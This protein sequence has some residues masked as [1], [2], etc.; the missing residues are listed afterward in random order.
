M[1]DRS[2]G[3]STSRRRFIGAA[4]SAVVGAGVASGLP[5]GDGGGS[6][7]AGTGAGTDGSADESTGGVQDTDTPTATPTPPDPVW[8]LFQFDIANTGHQPDGR[9]PTDAVG[10]EWA[11]VDGGSY[12]TTPVVTEAE[13]FA[14]DDD[15]VVRALDVDS[16]A[17]RWAVDVPLSNSRMTIQNRVLYVPNGETGAELQALDAATGRRL[18]STSL[19]GGGNGAVATGDSVY[20]ATSGGVAKVSTLSESVSW[21]FGDI[22]LVDST[23][24]VAG[25]SVY[26][27]GTR[28]GKVV[29]LDVSS[30][31]TGWTNFVGGS[32]VDAP[33]VAGS[34]VF[35]PFGEHLVALRTDSGREL[36][37][38]EQPVGSSVVVAGDTVYGTTTRGEAFAVDAENGAPLWR[39]E[40]VAGSTPPVFVGNRLYVAGTGGTLAA[41]NPR[42]GSTAWSTSIGADV[43]A[44]PAVYAGEL[45]LGDEAGRLA[46]LAPGAGGGYDTPTPSPTATPTPTATP[47]PTSTA[48][49][50]RTV[51]PPPDDDGGGS[52]GGGSDGGGGGSDGGGDDD[53]DGGILLSPTAT[54]PS[55]GGIGIPVVGAVVAAVVAALGG[56]LLWWRR[57]QQDEYDPLG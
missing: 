16:G 44:N 38:Y 36:W 51:T 12:S 50:T 33:T 57:N 9:G 46:A 20:V 49:P 43:S 34:R 54:E 48:T 41:V 28:D 10:A 1:N 47:S 45:Y 4:G 24:A 25:S 6:A 15:G 23:I 11:H 39:T 31:S 29:Q 17:T 7:D 52:D 55:G 22:T 37:R 40:V 26:A 56:G 13:V 42:D 8:P 32:A 35:V 21:E 53:D 3:T 19:D 2:V 18:W 27:A 5:G 14:A 30:G